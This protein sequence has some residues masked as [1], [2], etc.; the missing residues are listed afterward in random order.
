MNSFVLKIIACFTM[1][2][3]HLRYIIPTKPI[4]MS[5]IGRL[6]FPIFAF[7]AVEGYA[8]TKN[9]KKYLLRLL[10]VATIAQIPYS[11]YFSFTNNLN[12]IF[13]LIFGLLCIWVYENLK[14][15]KYL[16]LPIIIGVMVFSEIINTDYSYY[17]IAIML[18][19]HIFKDK[20]II[21]TL[22]FII[23]TILFFI[24]HYKLYLFPLNMTVVTYFICVILG[25]VPCLLYNGKQGPKAK[26][27]FYLFYPL[28]IVFLLLL[29]NI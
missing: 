24:E 1:F 14:D 13:T 9:L 22:S 27:L 23:M 17:G 16:A 21:M 7:Q 26:Y 15:N 2:I 10:I 28:H 29:A 11:L 5:Y 4:F 25:I 12:V 8:H 6:A 3:D 20:K 19:F 18:I